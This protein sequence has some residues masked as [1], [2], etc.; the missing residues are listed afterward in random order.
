M[1]LSFTS[2]ISINKNKGGKVKFDRRTVRTK[3]SIQESTRLRIVEEIIE[4]R[5][6]GMPNISISSSE[7]KYII[8][9]VA[10]YPTFTIINTK[11][12][13]ICISLMK[14]INPFVEKEFGKKVVEYEP[15]LLGITKASL[16]TSS[17]IS[18]ASFQE[19]TK[20]LTDA[21]TLGKIDPLN[22]L[23]EN[24]IVGRLIPAGTGRIT[25]EYER[26]ANL[27]DKEI[28]EQRNKS[29]NDEIN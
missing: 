13:I 7:E 28:I 20:V 5:D 17:F 9:K 18:A 1:A 25:T 19:T 23:K 22:G 16:Q 11:L 27:K 12:A 3:M 6:S 26:L 21:A 2:F 29:Q 4:L 8:D 24:V 15:V 10:S 14:N